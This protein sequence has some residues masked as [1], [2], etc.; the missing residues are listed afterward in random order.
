LAELLAAFTAIFFLRAWV[1][2]VRNRVLQHSAM[3]I[4]CDLRIELFTHLQTLSLRYFDNA[5]TG[6]MVARI[7]QDTGEV[8]NLTNGFLINLIAD[9][10][11]V[12]AVLGL[13]FSI[14]WR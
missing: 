8:Y 4:V 13:Q 9:S 11:T 14:D 1:T 12:V 10:V 7:A 5:K 2:M 3:T 6:E